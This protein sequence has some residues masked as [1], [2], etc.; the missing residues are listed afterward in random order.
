MANSLASRSSIENVINLSGRMKT[1][2]E[3]VMSSSRVTTTRDSS[4]IVHIDCGW[5][6]GTE[7]SNQRK[8]IY[9]EC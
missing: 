6:S 3:F 7:R 2:T 1:D 8:S 9:L 4:S 5:K